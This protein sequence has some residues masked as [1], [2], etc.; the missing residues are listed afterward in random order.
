[1]YI[2]AVLNPGEIAAGDGPAHGHAGCTRFGLAGK[3]AG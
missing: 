2:N 3:L 1:M